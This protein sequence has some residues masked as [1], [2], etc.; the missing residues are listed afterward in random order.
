MGY[1]TRE[2]GIKCYTPEN[3]PEILYIRSG[4][5]NSMAGILEECRNHFG[6]DIHLE[7]IMITS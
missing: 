3:T 5:D 1:Y 6:K 4:Y 2:N 7:D